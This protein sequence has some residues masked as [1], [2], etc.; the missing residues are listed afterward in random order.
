M[1]SRFLRLGMPRKPTAVDGSGSPRI[2]QNQVIDSMLMVRRS[3][4]FW[5][6]FVETDDR[7]VTNGI[8]NITGYTDLFSACSGIVTPYYR[9]FADAEDASS[10]L[11]LTNGIMDLTSLDCFNGVT[12]RLPVCPPILKGLPSNFFFRR[13]WSFSESFMTTIP[14]VTRKPMN[15]RL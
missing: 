12:Q 15:F 7:S 4:G 13:A 14:C 2:R 8:H 9:V 10:Y 3:K 5:H 6:Y 1:G 11:F